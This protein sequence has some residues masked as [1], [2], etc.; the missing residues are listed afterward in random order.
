[1]NET[2]KAVLKDIVEDIFE[3]MDELTEN[4]T[5]KE[6]WW[7]LLAYTTSLSRIKMRVDEDIW[8]DFGLD[9]DIDGKYL[10]A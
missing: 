8:Q 2:T 10:Q 3:E 1:M 9:I 7:Q 5:E 6:N 4:K